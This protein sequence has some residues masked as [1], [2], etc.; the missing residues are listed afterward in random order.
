MRPLK[1]PMFRNGGP[2]KEGIMDGMKEPQAI[3]TVGNNANRDAM[4]REK[5]AFFLPFLGANALRTA[6]LRAAPRIANFFRTQVG[7]RGPGQARVV[8]PGTGKTTQLGGGKSVYQSGTKLVDKAGPSQPIYEPN[9]AGRIIMQDPTVRTAGAIIKGVTSPAVKGPVASAARLVFSPT[10]LATGLYYANGKFFN[11][12]TNEEVPPPDG[13]VVL[14]DR[15]GTS[16]APGGGDPN[17]FL[18]P[19]KKEMSD[20]ER[21]AAMNKEMDARK[22]YYYELMGMDKMKKDAAYNTLID[23]SNQIR[24]GGNIKD[25]LKSGDLVSNVINSLSKNLDKSVD[26]KKQIDAAILKAEITKDVN[27]EKDQLDAKV[28]NAQL[29]LYNKKLDGLDLRESIASYYDKNKVM[30]SGSQLASLAR[31]TEGIDAKVEDTQAVKDW[32]E[33]NN[34]NEAGYFETL[35]KSGNLPAGNYVINNR[36]FNFDGE[37]ITALL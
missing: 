33:E 28:K 10:G 12:D 29:A 1:R 18:E 37:K 14:G 16:G 7:T 11:K 26:L 21:K 24:E 15:V 19:R 6:A 20:E 17:M 3:N 25:Q 13:E 2:I 4:G 36:I 22:K 8:V 27:R 23:A 34:S 9:L 32:M 35:V 5:H 31:V 30:P